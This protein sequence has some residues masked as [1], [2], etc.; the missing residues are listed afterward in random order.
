MNDKSVMF[1]TAH[2]VAPVSGLWSYFLPTPPI[3]EGLTVC[4]HPPRLVLG[5]QL[6]RRAPGSSSQIEIRKR[7]PGRVLHDEA[8]VIVLLDDPGRWEAAH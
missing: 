3:A 4:G 1:G 8:H 6:D 2:N 7:L 5:E